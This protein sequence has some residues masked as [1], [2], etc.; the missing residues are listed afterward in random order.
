MKPIIK[1]LCCLFV[2]HGFVQKAKATHI[3]GGELLYSY[4]GGKQYKLTLVL[5]GDC[6]GNSFASLPTSIPVVNIARNGIVET[7]VKLQ[8]DAP[9]GEE[10]TPICQQMLPQSSCNGGTIPGVKKFSYSKI[11]TIADTCSQ[12]TFNF[13]GALGNS[14]AGRSTAITNIASAGSAMNLIATLNNTS[15]PNN[16]PVFTANLSTFFCVNKPQQY[17][18]GAVDPDGDE[19]VYTLV[20]GLANPVTP[21]AY[22][23]GYSAQNPVSVSGNSSFSTTSGQFNF[24]PN[25]AQISMV[26]MKVSEYRGGKL[27][28]SI[29]RELNFVVLN[30]C[31]NNPPTGIISNS[32]NS[33]NTPNSVTICSGHPGLDFNINPTDADGDRLVVKSSNLPPGSSFVVSNNN[34][35]APQGRFTWNTAAAPNG[36]YTFFL[37]VTDDGCPLSSSQT[38]AYTIHIITPPQVT[39]TQLSLTHCLYKAQVAID[40]TGTDAPWKLQITQGSTTV[41]N[42]H[43]VAQSFL[44]SLSAGNYH[45]VLKSNAATCV[46]EKN[47]T[48]ADSGKFPFPPVLNTDP[49]GYCKGAAPIALQATGYPNAIFNWID[50]MGNTIG[51]SAPLPP[52]SDTGTF[53]W[54]VAQQYK[55]CVSDTIT[56]T[57]FVSDLANAFFELPATAC[58]GDTVSVTYTGDVLPAARYTWHWHDAEVVAG[59]EKGPY[60]IYLPSAGTNPVS[61]QV[62]NRGCLSAL[63]TRLVRVRPVPGN[64]ISAPDVCVYDSVVLQYQ[65]HTLPNAKYLWNI[66]GAKEIKGSGAGPYTI[67]YANPGEKSI[68]LSVNY[69]GCTN[70]TTI[71]VKVFPQPDIRIQAEI[72]NYCMGD[73]VFLKPEGATTY[74]WLQPQQVWTGEDDNYFSVVYNRTTFQLKGTSSEGCSNTAELT[75]P[76][77]YSCCEFYYPNAFSP[78]GDGSND[79]FNIKT[80]GNYEQY[81]L[82]VYNRWGQEVFRTLD[83]QRG[84]NGNI[85]GSPAPVDT[86]YYYFNA[87]CYNGKTEE[88]KGNVILLR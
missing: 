60:R 85:N 47:I 86:Y 80:L 4:V 17:N 28:G 20:P 58:E 52:T 2:L 69:E 78:N 23:T 6:A 26:V 63:N 54:R 13:E 5:Y 37:T 34:T 81:L 25:T 21:V 3:L 44:D 27:V 35:P 51:S 66:P 55:T 12:W 32:A 59:N 82:I 67:R 75:I 19:L 14:S 36:T 1:I 31:S 39:V 74:Q 42:M 50:N 72:R 38:I 62:D 83:E 24:T 64:V 8:P 56:A 46:S 73:S 61:L 15:G 43:N 76:N 84:W 71:T 48:I 70:D 77:V 87:K 11:V 45:V 33:I 7:F 53:Y 79:R 40:L 65:S 22:S 30:N 57:V 88:R 9:D 18:T 10:V 41:R 16:S 29:M 49:K 68:H